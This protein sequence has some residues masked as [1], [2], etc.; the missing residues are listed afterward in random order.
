MTSTDTSDDTTAITA[1][2]TKLEPGRQ[3]TADTHPVGVHDRAVSATYR[4]LD[5]ATAA[6]RRLGEAGFPVER[7]SLIGQGLTSE[8]QVHGFVSVG[9]LA[10]SGAGFG[11]WA[12]GL[13]GLLTGAAALFIPGVGPLFVLGPLAAGALGAVEGGTVGAGIGALVGAFVERNHIPKYEH[14]IKTGG[15]MLVVHGSEEDVARAER[16]LQDSASDEIERHDTHRA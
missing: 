2:A 16:I 7:V 8:T 12:G 3:P 15:Y 10:K 11:A 5:D 1:D 4:T 6:V 14:V 13:F 9:D